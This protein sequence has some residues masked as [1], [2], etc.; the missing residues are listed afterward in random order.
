MEFIY[1]TPLYKDNLTALE[2]DY[3]YNNIF[4]N[5]EANRNRNFLVVK[6]TDTGREIYI[7]F[8]YNNSYDQTAFEAYENQTKIYCN[9][10]YGEIIPVNDLCEILTACKFKLLDEIQDIWVAGL[11]AD[12]FEI[13][14]TK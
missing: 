12:I 7:K 14:T 9:W 3:F 13:M 11:H 2:N 1:S 4:D 8:I 5:I 6:N 10:H